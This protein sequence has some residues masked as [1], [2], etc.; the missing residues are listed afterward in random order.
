PRHAASP[1]VLTDRRL[2][3]QRV[4]RH[5]VRLSLP[6]RR[7]SDLRVGQHVQFGAST[8]IVGG[9]LTQWDARGVREAGFLTKP[10]IVRWDVTPGSDRKSTRLNSSHVKSS[11]AVFCLKKK[12]CDQCGKSSGA[13]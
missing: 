8:Y 1:C 10:K 11:Y 5:R 12:K 9:L 7:S 13:A 3:S 2:S 6:T 4:R